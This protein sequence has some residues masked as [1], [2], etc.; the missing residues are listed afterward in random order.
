M[1][2][3]AILITTHL[4]NTIEFRFTQ[5]TAAIIYFNNYLTLLTWVGTKQ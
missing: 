5:K 1:S 3:I 2:N 4:V